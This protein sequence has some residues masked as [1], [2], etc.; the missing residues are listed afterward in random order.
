MRKR[1]K[2]FFVEKGI[3]AQ[4][5]LVLNSFAKIALVLLTFV[6][7]TDYLM[8][9]TYTQR[10]VFTLFL[11]LVVLRRYVKSNIKTNVLMSSVLMAFVLTIFLMPK[12]VLMYL[13]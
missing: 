1:K 8:T 12:L 5:P 3:F 2:T 10:E 4:N 9:L 11:W 13:F 6:L 7:V